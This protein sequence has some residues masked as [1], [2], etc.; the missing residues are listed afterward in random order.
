M[1]QDFYNSFFVFGQTFYLSTAFLLGFL[2]NISKL[3]YATLYNLVEP[4]RHCDLKA[5][6]IKFFMKIMFT[7]ISSINNLKRENIYDRRLENIELDF[8]FR[9]FCGTIFGTQ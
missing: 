6:Q 1:D 7:Q 2:K 4:V 9:L 8:L 5:M 3:K